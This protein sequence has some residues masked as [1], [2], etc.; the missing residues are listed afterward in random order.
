MRE[1]KKRRSGLA[2]LKGS[3]TKRKTKTAH[4]SILSAAFA[5]M[6]LFF[7]ALLGSVL[8]SCCSLH[9]D[10][11]KSGMLGGHGIYK[12]FN[13]SKKKIQGYYGG[14]LVICMQGEGRYVW[15]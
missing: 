6:V 15:K 13:I 3:K 2:G 9:C 4:G 10:K 11:D 1:G 7:A 5:I 12:L 8:S 14:R